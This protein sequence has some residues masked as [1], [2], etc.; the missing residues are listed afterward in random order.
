M[1]IHWSTLPAQSYRLLAQPVIVLSLVVKQTPG[2]GFRSQ[3]GVNPVFIECRA[4]LVYPPPRSPDTMVRLLKPMF[5]DAVKE[6]L[7]RFPN[8]IGNDMQNS[9]RERRPT[10]HS[11]RDKCDRKSLWSG[12]LQ[13]PP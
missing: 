8:Y 13:T 5:L 4:I 2:E 1:C 10:R 3:F 12:V 11:R 7:H 6:N 9:I